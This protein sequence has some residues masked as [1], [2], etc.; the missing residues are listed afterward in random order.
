MYRLGTRLL[1]LWFGPV[2][3]PGGS[4][5]VYSNDKSPRTHNVGGQS[6]N[7]SA[8]AGPVAHHYSCLPAVGSGGRA[9]GLAC[10]RFL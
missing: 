7:L 5:S 9:G 6:S 8:K 1:A 4:I 3:V 10:P 2:F